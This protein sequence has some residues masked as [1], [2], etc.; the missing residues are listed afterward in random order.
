MQGIP[1]P[2]VPIFSGQPL[3]NKSTP[4]LF[5][6]GMSTCLYLGTLV[7]LIMMV[8]VQTDMAEHKRFPAE[9]LDDPSSGVCKQPLKTKADKWKC[10]KQMC[11]YEQGRVKWRESL[12][13]TSAVGLF[14]GLAMF[15][16]LR[17]LN[18]RQSWGRAWCVAGP[19]AFITSIV[20]LLGLKGVRGYFAFHGGQRDTWRFCSELA[21][22][23][24]TPSTSSSSS[25]K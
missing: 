10:M 20:G 17:T 23:L 3:N 24:S 12:A 16:I 19:T 15:V 5:A 25:S 22:Q 2:A 18:Q 6:L 9:T 14:V 21:D 7:M 11:R 1:P 4:S 8:I 13:F